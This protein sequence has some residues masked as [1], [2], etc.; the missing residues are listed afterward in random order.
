LHSQY[1]DSKESAQAFVDQLRSGIN[2]HRLKR[3]KKG[4]RLSDWADALW[5]AQKMVQDAPTRDLVEVRAKA[6]S[7]LASAARSAQTI[8]VM[9][10]GDSVKAT[11]K[12]TK[13]VD[14]TAMLKVINGDK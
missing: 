9:M 2:P 7:A 4:Q 5:Q 6:L 13:S 10:G 11:K 8:I 1:Y 12:A 14:K 3:F